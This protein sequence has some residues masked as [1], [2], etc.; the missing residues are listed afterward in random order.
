MEEFKITLLNG[1]ELSCILKT[2][3][4]KAIEKDELKLDTTGRYLSVSKK[5]PIKDTT[6]EREAARQYG[7][8]LFTENAW[9]LLKHADQIMSDSRMFLAPVD[10]QNGIAYTGRS[11]FQNPTLGI[12]LEWW[13]NYPEA[14]VDANNNLVW[15]ISGSPL[16]GRN[17]CSAVS[18]DGEQLKINQRTR[19]RDIWSSFMKANNRYTEAKQRCEA[20]SLEDVICKFRGEDYR[21]RIIEMKY[22]TRELVM[23]WD[24]DRLQQ[25]YDA[26]KKNFNNML[27]INRN[28]FLRANSDK[29]KAFYKEYLQRTEA[30]KPIHEE[31]VKRRTQL[32]A[33]LHDGTIEGD[34]HALLNDAGKEYNRM[35]HELS[36]FCNDFM[37][38]TFPKNINGIRIAHIIGEGKRLSP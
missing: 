28:E 36:M 2:E 38:E 23:T 17:C 14:A 25:N 12:Y 21:N 8:R 27:A 10:V 6:F 34:Y 20:Y 9:L 1:K 18:P 31:Y 29:I 7:H 37:K 19:F 3:Q 30:L 32:K 13:L 16:S 15:Y 11:G 5:Q 26:L 24:R 4:P 33:Q 22:D 35:K